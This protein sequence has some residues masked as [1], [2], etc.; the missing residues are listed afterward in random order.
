M[1]F[2]IIDIIISWHLKRTI[3]SFQY[4]PKLFFINHFSSS[5]N[6]KRLFLYY[7]CLAIIIIFFFC[8]FHLT[9]YFTSQLSS[10]YFAIFIS[11][12]YRRLWTQVKLHPVI[13]KAAI[14]VW[15]WRCYPQARA[16]ILIFFIFVFFIFQKI[17]FYIYIILISLYIFYW[18]S[19]TLSYVFYIHKMY[20]PE[21]ILH[22]IKVI[23]ILFNVF[24]IF[25]F[26]QYI[27]KK[28]VFIYNI[29]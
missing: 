11:Q 12:I 21:C 14:I 15:S 27:W 4:K 5:S 1:N 18:L 19:F 23:W 29:E 6:I 13:I 9:L 26:D 28:Y 25:H 2:N 20:H 16:G 24:Y 8:S 22:C 3:D 10:I 17:V 7:L